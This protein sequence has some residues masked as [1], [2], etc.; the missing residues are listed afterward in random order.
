M[1]VGNQQDAAKIEAEMVEN[2]CYKGILKR[3]A[4]VATSDADGL[5][6]NNSDANLFIPI[7]RLTKETNQKKQIE[8]I[9]LD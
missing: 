5:Y 8:V 2:K 4:T 3:Q 9:V 6:S 1:E 7:G